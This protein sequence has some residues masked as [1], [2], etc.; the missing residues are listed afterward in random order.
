TVGNTLYRLHYF[1]QIPVVGLYLSGLTALFFLFATVTGVI[2]H[3]R[4]IVDKFYAFTVKPSWKQIWTNA[5]TVLGMIGLPFQIVYA[6]TGAF[7]GILILL[8]IPS[9]LILFGGDQQ[10]IIAAVQPSA[11]LTYS[12]SSEVVD[13]TKVDGL[14]AA[15]KDRFP[16]EVHL[17]NV[18]FRNYGREDGTMSLYFDDE[19]TVLGTGEIIYRVHT[20][21]ILFENPPGGGKYTDSVISTIGRL[22]FATYG[23]VGLRIIYFI[24]AM[25]TCFMLIS[26]VL[27]WQA[28][29]NKRTYTDKQRRFHHRVT[30]ANLAVCLGL[31]PATA[32]IFVANKLIPMDWDGRALV[33]NG[34]F[35]GSW[36]V[37][38]I[39][40]LFWD[41]YARINRNYLLIGGL[42][43]LLIPVI[44]GLATG[45]W[46]WVTLPQAWYHVASVDIA[47]LMTGITAI[48]AVLYL[49]RRNPKTP[50]E[51]VVPQAK[52]AAKPSLSADIPLV[53]RTVS[54][55]PNNSGS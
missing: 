10:K 43:A 54:I 40:G 22:H 41:Q 51:A 37:L 4:N 44:N 25:L 18:R 52:A 20:E 1:G 3:W 17:R 14:I 9:A 21:E 50:E 46:I 27:L 39:L 55:K 53:P 19:R 35:F 49:D 29:R 48:G 7:Y 5:H 42:L 8:L 2:V 23:G 45:D 12:D 38:I 11:A 34:I 13:Y 33:V 6:V 24:L 30:K 47:W 28:A 31:F 32:T 36:L 15:A 26:G 16:E